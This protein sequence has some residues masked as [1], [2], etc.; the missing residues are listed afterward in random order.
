M[1]IN[2]TVVGA[3]VLVLTL[4][5]T[6]GAAQAQQNDTRAR[7]E[8]AAA[9]QAAQP[10]RWLLN[11]RPSPRWIDA[12]RFWFERET[13]AGHDYALVDAAARRITPLID[14]VALAEALRKVLPDTIPVDAND[15][16]LRDLQV[17]GDPMVA[18]FSAFDREWRLTVADNRLEPGGRK[19]DPGLVVSPD[20]SKGIFFKGPDLWLRDLSS[21]KE[22][23]LTTDG[24]QFY[25]YGVPPHATGNP[26]TRPHVIWS[27]DSKR[28]LTAQTDDRQVREMPVISFA[29]TDGTVRPLAWSVRAALPGDPHVTRF[30]MLAIDVESGKQVAAHYPTIPSA[31][32]ND[33]PINGN[34]AWWSS[35]GRHAYFVEI[36]RGER[37]VNVVEFDTNSGA[38]RVLFSETSPTYIDLASNV[39]GPTAIVPLPETNQLVWYSERSGWAHLY[40]YDVAE[41]R[42]I[43]PLTQGDWLVRD[44]IGIDRKRRELYVTIAG[45]TARKDPYYR[46]V[47]RVGIDDGTLTIV[48]RSDGDHTVQRQPDYGLRVQS[49]EGDGS[50]TVSGISPGGDLYVETIQR[51]DRPAR[52]LVRDRDGRELVVVENGDASGMPEWW[53][54][55]EPVQLRAADGKTDISGVVFRP[56]DF[57]PDRKYPVVDYIYGGPQVSYVPE[58]FS[59]PFYNLAATIAE[60]GFVVVMIDGRGTA[61]R[62]KA[63]H[64]ESYGALHTA[65]N[66]EDHIAG[67]RQLARRYPYIDTARVGIYGHSGGGYMTA[68][69]M[70]RFPEFF[71]VGV[72]SSGNYDQRLFWHTWGER[73]HGLLDGDNYL[74]QA[75]LTYAKNLKGRI[76]FIHGME[77]HGVHPGGLFQLT[78]VLMEQDKTF[79]MLLLPRAGHSLPGYGLRR[80]LDYF[81]QH[82]AGGQP[83][84]DFR[85]KTG[86]EIIAEREAARGRQPV[87]R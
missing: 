55:P 7:Y 49:A 30:R 50:A 70:F 35:G 44:V 38:T 2:Q 28:I 63:F 12:N 21:G 59:E 27:P 24:Q 86:R 14:V 52:T 5:N 65:S 15:L 20:G 48:S 74:N 40:L 31:R 25:A 67:I 69:A 62:S 16:P 56:S 19:V 26:A 4:A 1:R 37:R 54:W 22:S 34:R 78:Q 73:Y 9:I 6:S 8:R 53:R 51:P 3:S 43:R 79:D 29:P 17:G 10:D 87:T 11:Q 75:D 61:E 83:P 13:R 64:D 81:V 85:M 58:A 23:P 72:A 84:L 36:E 46:E 68:S 76:L 71:K 42:L 41:G 82:L 77:D 18:T 33:S 57:S 80:M 60:V 47:A 66:V 45:N 32:M 39:Y